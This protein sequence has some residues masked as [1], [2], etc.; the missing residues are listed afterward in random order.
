MSLRSVPP[1][2]LCVL[3]MGGC[4]LASHAQ[5]KSDSSDTPKRT[6]LKPT[7]LPEPFATPSANNGARIIPR[8]AGAELKMP[9]GFRAEV[10]AEGFDNPRWVTVAPNGD[11]F[12]AEAGP[13]R[14]IALR[15]GADGKIASRE[16]FA[17]GLQRPFGMAFWQ[18]WLYVGTPSAVVRIPYRAGQLKAEGEPQAIVSGLPTNGHW[19]RSLAFN[20]RTGKFYVSIGSQAD[21]GELTD[22]RRA[23]VCEFNPDGSG[24]RVYASGLRNAVGLACNPQTG[25]VWAAVQERDQLGDDLVP[26][27]VTSVK[28]GGYYGWPYYYIGAHPDSRVS[29]K[30][31]LAA[32]SLVPDVLLTSH[33]AAMCMLFYT[34]KQFPPQYRGDAF[35]AL[36]GSS[37]RALRVGYSIIRAPFKNGKPVGGYED[38]VTGWMLAENDNRVWGRPVGL[39]Q[40]ADGSLLMVDDGA[41]KL[42]RI[43]Y[44]K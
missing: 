33:T 25:A 4:P 32:K 11:I 3:W 36:H 38:F 22:E 5:E 41:N 18:N 17:T 39:A 14:I 15:P 6:L 13:G 27:F 9:S 42:W 21:I 8:P 23:T 35:V 28:E 7:D 29:A 1:I 10:V 26:D 44:H 31:E 37:N 20:P 40:A 24:F 2:L 12:V 34:G 19:T 16:V 30:P 43:S